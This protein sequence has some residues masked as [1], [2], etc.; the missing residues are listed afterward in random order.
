MN[1][2]DALRSRSDNPLTDIW[3][4]IV[5]F[6]GGSCGTATRYVL[7]R[8]LNILPQPLSIHWGTLTAN[9]IACFVYALLSAL[10]AQTLSAVNSTSRAKRAGELTSRALGM[11]FCGGLS[12]M[13]TLALEITAG[14]YGWVYAII[15]LLSG[16]FF[17]LLGSILGNAIGSLISGARVDARGRKSKESGSS[18]DNSTK[19]NLRKRGRHAGRHNVSTLSQAPSLSQ[20]QPLAQMQRREKANHNDLKAANSTER[21]SSTS[22][23]RH[24]RRKRKH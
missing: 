1:D 24:S 3:I 5:V 4:Y 23:V 17:A 12:T 13:S 14:Q 11:G 2:R 18:K 9:L 19:S 7:G 6:L 15:S 20:S 10:L 22:S 8:T 21:A 16:V